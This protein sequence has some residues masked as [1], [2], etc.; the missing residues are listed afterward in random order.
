MRSVSQKIRTGVLELRT[1]NGP[2]YVNPSFWERL[3][4]LWIFRNF[5]S[6]SRQVLSLRQ[7]RVIDRLCRTGST[8]E[9]GRVARVNILGA[10]ENARVI[11]GR[12][13]ALPVASNN[14][15]EIPA[16]KQPMPL[17]SAVGA[18]VVT[19]SNKTAEHANKG[20]STRLH[21][22]R[23]TEIFT[24]QRTLSG[25]RQASLE[26]KLSSGQRQQHRQWLE[27]AMAATLAGV[28][29]G[30]LLYVRELRPLPLPSL[31]RH[32]IA[33]QPGPVPQQAPTASSVAPT[34]S[35]ATA[36]V[37]AASTNSSRQ[38]TVH[39][40]LGVRRRPVVEPESSSTT[41]IQLSG[42]PEHSFIYP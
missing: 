23:V 25:S 21:A 40:A 27:W 2:L 14:L 39:S 9:V 37:L 7:Q 28:L 8:I 30:V 35:P 10:I 1:P 41:R 12:G 11:P 22:H 20:K 34:P 6:L 31:S 3:Y 5:R 13:P 38:E 17:A 32:S 33:T 29:F 26:P 15:L 16:R 36:P 42:A 19:I 4:L 18:P 24:R